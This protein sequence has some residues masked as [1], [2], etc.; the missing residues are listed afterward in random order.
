[1]KKFAWIFMVTCMGLS[2]HAWGEEPV[3]PIDPPTEEPDIFTLSD[4]GGPLSSEPGI[5]GQTYM[6]MG[7][8]K[9]VSPMECKDL[10]ATLQQ[11]LVDPKFATHDYL[12]EYTLHCEEIQKGLKG[13]LVSLLVEPRDEHQIESLADYRQRAMEANL[14]GMSL[15][16]VPL[17]GIEIEKH[18]S[19]VYMPDLMNP[20]PVHRYD[21]VSTNIQTFPNFHQFQMHIR[22]ERTL[23][24]GARNVSVLKNY[25]ERFLVPTEMKLFEDN[26]LRKSNVILIQSAR[27][28]VFMTNDKIEAISNDTNIGLCTLFGTKFCMVE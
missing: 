8:T 17:K 2:V 7:M 15:V 24:R 18:I 13:L 25:L 12:Y 16:F 27:R 6:T 28:N 4:R 20:K 11:K 9:T 5:I 19:G 26:G 23:L 1:M 10:V 22:N 14:Y 21:I 3:T